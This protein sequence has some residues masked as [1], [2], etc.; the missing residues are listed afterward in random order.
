MRLDISC[1][2][3]HE[4]PGLIVSENTNNKNQNAVCYN[5]SASS[6]KL[7]KAIWKWKLKRQ[8]TLVIFY[9][10]YFYDIMFAFLYTRD[11]QQKRPCKLYCCTWRDNQTE[12][13]IWIYAVC[14]SLLLSPVA[15]EELK[16]FQ[17]IANASFKRNWTNDNLFFCF[18]FSISLCFLLSFSA[19]NF[20][21]HLSSAFSFYFNKLSFGKMSICK[22]ERLNVKQRRSRW[23]GSLNRLIWIYA[24]CK[25]LLLSPPTKKPIS[26]LIRAI[27]LIRVFVV[28]MKE[29]FILG[30]PKCAQWRFWSDYCA[31]VQAVLNIRWANM[32]EGT[33]RLISILFLWCWGGLV[34]Q[35]CRTFS[36]RG[37]NWYWLTVR[38]GLLSLQ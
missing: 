11:L 17:F 13:T 26:L 32:S 14:K 28:R 10:F 12:S 29:L 3:P 7:L 15:M 22:V 21:Q 6:V 23:D 8:N 18:P 2:L 16:R 5:I 37:V 19:S 38:Q 35:R 9:H 33:L 31:N 20:R 30:Y 4:M 24:V 27:W 36:H 25:S 34:M 1:D